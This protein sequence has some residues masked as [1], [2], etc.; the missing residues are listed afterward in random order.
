[1]RVRLRS[2]VASRR[3]DTHG[4]RTLWGVGAPTSYQGGSFFLRWWPLALV[5]VAFAL[6]FM[7]GLRPIQWEAFLIVAAIVHARWMPC[8]FT[9]RE[10]G[11]ALLGYELTYR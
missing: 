7:G 9:I 5:G 1:M 6:M 4:G 3:E 2:A 10:D 8:Q 11:I